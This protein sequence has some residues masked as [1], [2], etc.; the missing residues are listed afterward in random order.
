MS[1]KSTQLNYS[2]PETN[3]L[4]LLPSSILCSSGDGTNF[5]TSIEDMEEN[6]Y[7]FTW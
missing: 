5:G 7:T 1:I 6:D 2:A 3:L 4:E